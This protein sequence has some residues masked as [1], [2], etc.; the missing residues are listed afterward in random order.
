MAPQTRKWIAAGGTSLA[1]GGSLGLLVQSSNYE[2]QPRFHIN[3]TG[4]D[5]LGMDRLLHGQIAYTTARLLHG[6][7]SWAGVEEKK[8]VWIASGGALLFMSA[9]EWLDGHNPR[10]GWSWADVGANIA[11]TAL[12]ATQQLGWR[13]QRLQL[14][15]SGVPRSYPHPDIEQQVSFLFGDGLERAVKDYNQQTY[16]LSANLHSMGWERMP[17]WLNLA[18]GLGAENLY[19]QKENL[20][21]GP[22]GSITFD[23]RD[24]PRR[25][26]WYLSPDIDLTKIPTNSKFLR[27]AFF[28]L[29]SIKVPLPALELT[30]GK[31]KVKA[32]AF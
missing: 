17:P 14:K 18:V 29:N 11:G 2:Y 19:G 15:F 13:E 3:K 12:F 7:L 5:Y 16:W 27:T 26:Q 32:L 21:R 31:I 24:L 1:F 8:G 28:V 6:T 10:W 23:R 22:G 9:K 4:T 25:R 30:D 20:Q